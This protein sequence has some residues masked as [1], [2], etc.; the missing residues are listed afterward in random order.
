MQVISTIQ[1]MKLERSLWTGSVG[2]V[3]TMGSLHAG[4]LSLFQ[5]ARLH[6]N[7]VVGSI[8]VNPIQFAPHEDFNHYPRN[9]ERDLHLLEDLNVDVVFTP[10]N[11][12]MYPHGFTTY[13]DP[14][15]PLATEVEGAS[16]PGHFCGVAT[17]VLKLFHIIQPHKTYFGQKDAQ[18]VAVIS[19][20][21]QDLNLLIELFARPTLREPDG[22]A[23][24]SRNNYLS[25][26][27]RSVARIVYKALRAGQETFLSSSSADPATVRK[28]MAN[29]IATEPSVRLEYAELR[30]PNTFLP[31]ETLQAPAALLLAV[32]LG[33]T[34]LIDNFILHSDGT[35][36]TGTFP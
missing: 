13:V 32:T 16:R 8:F 29:V 3:P 9:I 33:K 36:D 20:M 1:A 2:F 31:L 5:H 7:I 19:R 6:N 11:S 22:L 17:I 27:D 10:S 15:G 35:W 23:M 28:A 34:R 18:Q 25:A 26:H 30:D 12:E 24:S 4:H 21:I 14:T